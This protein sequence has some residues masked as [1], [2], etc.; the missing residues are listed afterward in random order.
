MKRSNLYFISVSILLTF[1]SNSCTK[2]DEEVYDQLPVDQFGTN[3]KEIN[4]LIAPIYRTLKEVYPSN[5]FLLSE[6]SA[7]MAIIPT[8]K[9]GD[10]WDG[11]IYKELRFHSWTPN[12][13]RFRNSYNGATQGISICNKIYNLIEESQNTPNKE[14]ILAEI[15]GV[16]AYWYYMLLDYFGNV[17]VVTDFNDVSKPTTKS[18]KE[19]YDFVLSE[20][21]AIK[22]VLRSDVTT[23]SY[24]KVTKGFAYTLLAKM[25]LNALVWNPA[26]GPKWQE[27]IDACNV[28]MQLP[29]ILEPNWKANFA[30]QN[31]NS[32]EIIFPIVFSKADGGNQMTQRTLH[33]LDPI[34]LGMKTEGWNG[35]C[36][37]P[38]YVKA[39]DDEDKRL[40]W[41]F[42]TG[43]M[44]DPS[45]GQVLITAHNRPLIHRV[46]VE[47][48]YNIDADGWG[49]TEQED[50]ARCNKWEFEPGLSGDSENDFAIFRLADVY[51]MKAEALTR[52]GIDNGEATRLVNEIRKRAFDDPSK[53]KSQVTLEDIYKERRFELAWELYARQ[54]Q[55]RFNTF[56]DA[57]PGWKGVSNS[58]YLLFP[59]PTT[60]IDANPGLTQ[61]PGY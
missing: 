58:K 52:L 57:I 20:L 47:M 3:T 14:Q 59:I 26:D 19:V 42:L 51:L 16:R 31:Q 37:M 54:D 4:S 40:G 7:D 22:D 49:Q 9:G 55:I 1:L 61:N 44:I 17:P 28:V 27:C 13:S 29:Y 10:Y 24:G 34:A 38:D 2:L 53:L 30:I 18:R 33:Y 25:Y 32:R 36:A 39:Y 43:P 11:G 6:L 5:F 12:N 60:A 56:L 48:K 46:E 50:G 23:A 15:R 41:T 35:V 45:T 8:K 21:N